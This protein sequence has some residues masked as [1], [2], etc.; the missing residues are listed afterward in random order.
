MLRYLYTYLLP[1]FILFFSITTTADDRLFDIKTDA[2]I[3]AFGDV[4]GAYDELVSLLKE[5]GMIDNGLNWAGGK[6][7]LV[8]MG[9]LVDRGPRSRDV[10]EL[11]INYR[12][13]NCIR[14]RIACFTGEP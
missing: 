7:H 8:S 1:F 6:S 3:V 10:V 9:D 13:G 11:M 5:T 14:R 2:K 4:H 12:K